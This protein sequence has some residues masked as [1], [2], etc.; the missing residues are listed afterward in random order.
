MASSTPIDFLTP[1]LVGN[2]QQYRKEPLA[3]L[4]LHIQ[5]ASFKF[6]ILIRRCTGSDEFS[7]ANQTIPGHDRFFPSF[8]PLVMSPGMPPTSGN[9][10]FVFFSYEQ[11]KPFAHFQALLTKATLLSSLRPTFP[12]GRRFCNC[13]RHHTS[14]VRWKRTASS[15]IFVRS[16]AGALLTS[17]QIIS[18]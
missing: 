18:I 1:Q 12:Y 15:C 7:W 16:F 6:S 8:S 5:E 9:N 2:D 14:R 10:L 17:R 11:R 13:Y 4:L 3:D